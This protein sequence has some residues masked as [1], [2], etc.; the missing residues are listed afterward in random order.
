MRTVDDKRVTQILV[1]AVPAPKQSPADTEA[2]VPS[3]PAL[4]A[5]RRGGIP[6]NGRL[7]KRTAAPSSA[8]PGGKTIKSFSRPLALP[9]IRESGNSAGSD[10]VIRQEPPWDTFKKYYKC[11]LA[12]T[13]AVCVRRS[14]R[15][16]AWAIRQYPSKDANRYW[17][18]SVQCTIKMWS[19][20][21]NVFIPLMPYILSASSTLSP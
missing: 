11:D 17:T 12:G 4:N 5:E 8:E 16:A 15:R 14:G 10:L 3:P 2:V 20:F 13:V 19:R 21:G 7:A 1:N 9:E 18:F 6:S